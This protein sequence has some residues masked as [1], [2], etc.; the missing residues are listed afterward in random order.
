MEIIKWSE[1][2]SVSNTLLDNQHKELIKLINE[3]FN[4]ISLR[5][6]NEQI[7]GI[8]NALYKY[9]LYHFMKKS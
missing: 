5:K 8:I 7:S 4:A 6:T 2:Y 9:A 1:I 3:I